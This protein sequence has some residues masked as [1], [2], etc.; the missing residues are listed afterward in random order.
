M[1]LKIRSVCFLRMLTVY[2]QIRDMLFE[3]SVVS[4]RLSRSSLLSHTFTPPSPYF[5]P[6]KEVG[7]SKPWPSFVWN[8]ICSNYE[9][10]GV[11]A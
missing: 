8:L 4:L 11:L 6:E 5:S 7:T 9:S 2:S 1:D 3:Y 10:G